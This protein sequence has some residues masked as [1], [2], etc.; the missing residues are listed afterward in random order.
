MA[1]ERSTATDKH[2]RRIAL[3]FFIICLC[4]IGLALR[5]GYHMIIKGDEYAQRAKRQQ[6]KD[7]TV[8]ATRGEILDR[9]GN[10]IAI[11]GTA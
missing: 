2:R 5:V 9:N 7:S 1:R 3:V 4:F 6:T 8:L 11:S 10:E